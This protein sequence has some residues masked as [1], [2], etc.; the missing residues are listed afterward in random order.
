MPDP[1]QRRA[2]AQRRAD[3]EAAA[4]QA[5]AAAAQRQIDAFVADME[6]RGVSPEPLQASL[7]NGR[8]VKSDQV[9]WYLN[10]AH[11]IA[12]GPGGQYFSLVVPGSASARWRG[13]SVPASPP[14]LVVARGGRDGE[15][16]DLRDFL[17]RASAA[18]TL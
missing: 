6:R 15:S 13:V 1:S 7:L 17:A 3:M 9:G 2:D 11:T 14:P 16:G 8:R 12:I 4:K 18:Y 10:A 5:E